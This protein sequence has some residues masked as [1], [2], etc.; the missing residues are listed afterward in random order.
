[1]RPGSR[2]CRQALPNLREVLPE[3]NI[4]VD[5]MACGPTAGL[6]AGDRRFE[7]DKQSRRTVRPGPVNGA[8]PPAFRFSPQRGQIPC[9]WA[10]VQPGA[11]VEA[12]AHP[13]HG[14][15]QIAKAALRVDE[16]GSFRRNRLEQDGCA[17]TGRGKR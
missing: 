1:M 8:I 17:G 15:F 3:N 11:G 9:P 16:R 12:V 7:A 10:Y 4:R 13:S 14:V 6:R 5:R 2:T